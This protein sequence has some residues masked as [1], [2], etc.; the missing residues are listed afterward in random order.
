MRYCPECATRLR[1]TSSRGGIPRRECP[2]CA[3]DRDDARHYGGNRQLVADG[4]RIEPDF[5][6]AD[7]AVDRDSDRD[8]EVIVLEVTGT[9]ARNYTIDGLGRT[10]AKCNIDYSP[11]APVVEAVYA[12]EVEANVD[13]W[14]SVED[15]R[16]AAAFGAI[17]SYSFPAT[18]LRPLD[19]EGDET[20]MEA[21]L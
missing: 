8:A 12:E 10:V 16:D 9:K 13:G 3:D 20:G 18:R 15:L 14:R 5:S 17:S 7:R 2:E 4:G 11:D 19:D 6:A 1:S 21:F